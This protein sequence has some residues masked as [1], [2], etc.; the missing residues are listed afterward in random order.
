MKMGDATF[1]SVHF[2]SCKDLSDTEDGFTQLNVS[3]GAGMVITQNR[4]Y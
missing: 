4:L 2:K 1:N 3:N